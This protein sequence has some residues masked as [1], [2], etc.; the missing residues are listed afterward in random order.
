MDSVST[1]K[2]DLPRS[3][4]EYRDSVTEDGVAVY[5]AREWF[6]DGEMVRRDAWVD[7]KRG[8]AAEA[9]KA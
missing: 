7:M 2:G 9:Q 3:A 4:L 8:Q 1:A 5:T 6:H